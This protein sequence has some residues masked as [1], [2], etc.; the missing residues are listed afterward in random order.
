MRDHWDSNY[1]KLKEFRAETGHCNVPTNDPKYRKLGQWVSSLRYKNKIG[2]LCKDRV[3]SLTELDFVWSAADLAWNKMFDQLVAYAEKNNTTNVHE[4]SG[5]N[6]KLA[7]WIHSQRHRQKSGKMSAE[8]YKSLEDIGFCW[9]VRGTEE[10]ED[11]PEVKPSEMTEVPAFVVDE[12]PEK[13]Y[14]LRV[15]K[16]IQYNGKGDLPGIL[17]RYIKNHGGEY[18]PHIPLPKGPVK[19]MLGSSFYK[20]H[21]IVWSGAGALPEEVLKYV[22]DEGVLPDY[23]MRIENYSEDE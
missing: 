7:R 14:S 1:K 13:L 21:E 12:A 20:Q 6:G 19:F 16:Y 11:I 2:E 9:I 18:P 23:G 3:A 17:E 22:E 4:R 8:R 10:E 5:D 15:G